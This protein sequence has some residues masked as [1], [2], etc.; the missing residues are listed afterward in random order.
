MTFR[1]EYS[2]LAPK[3]HYRNCT[4]QRRN[5]DSPLI[6]GPIGNR[7]LALFGCLQ[8]SDFA[9][10]SFGSATPRTLLLPQTLTWAAHRCLSR[11]LGDFEAFPFFA[12]ATGLRGVCHISRGTFISSSEA[13]SILLRIHQLE[14]HSCTSCNAL[15]HRCL[16]CSR[17]EAKG[18]AGMHHSFS[19][20]RQF[21]TVPQLH[22]ACSGN[23]GMSR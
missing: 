7:I 15:H 4:A 23:S 13:R 11:L 6:F 8:P 20:P 10:I 2:A 18:Q 22:S 9:S 21:S 1:P 5:A 19:L 14:S 3:S 12:P 16:Y 17:L